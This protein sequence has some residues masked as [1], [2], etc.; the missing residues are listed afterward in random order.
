ML[1]GLQRICFAGHPTNTQV[2]ETQGIFR[3]RK[4][5]SI[6]A[7]IV[8]ERCLSPERSPGEPAAPERQ[9]NRQIYM[10]AV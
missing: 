9:V 8:G 6:F 5:K 2:L 7:V 3:A 4:S 10:A 1:T